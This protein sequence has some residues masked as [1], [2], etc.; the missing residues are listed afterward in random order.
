MY[1]VYLLRSIA[2]PSE[3]YTG[4]TT[5]LRAR[6]ATHNAGG[7]PHTA[8]YRPWKLVAY[9]AFDDEQIAVH[10]EKYLKSGSGRAFAEKRFWSSDDVG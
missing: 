3:K 1:Y 9:F 10:F 8:K 5:D 4:Y 2:H 6:F 7:S